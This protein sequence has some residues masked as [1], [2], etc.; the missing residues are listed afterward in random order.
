MKNLTLYREVGLYLHWQLHV[1]VAAVTRARR[2]PW[3]A[4]NASTATC[5]YRF[6]QVSCHTLLALHLRQLHVALPYVQCCDVRCP[7]VAWVRLDCYN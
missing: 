6:L 7:D 5:E 1:A 2:V 3:P 4:S